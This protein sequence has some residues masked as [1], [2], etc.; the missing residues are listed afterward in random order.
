MCPA[1]TGGGVSGGGT[2]G[3][4]AGEGLD[5]GTVGLDG[6]GLA[7][8]AHCSASALRL[9]SARLRARARLRASARRCFAVSLCGFRLVLRK[10]RAMDRL[11]GYRPSLL[12]NWN[13]A[14]D[15]WTK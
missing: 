10:E 8:F 9:A 4:L 6:S 5:S 3:S 14:R 7:D 11:H 13:R 2:V 15:L 12:M 1:A